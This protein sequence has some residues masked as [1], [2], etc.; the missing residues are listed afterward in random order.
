MNV[1][2]LLEKFELFDDQWSPKI[3]A[4]T[5][6]QYVKLAKIEGEFIW[7]NHADEDE[8]FYIVKGEL[9]LKFRDREVHLK[10]GDLYVVPK[11]EDHLPIAP[12]ECWV[13][14]VEPKGTKHTGEIEFERTVA[15]EEQHWI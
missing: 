12:K 14:L 5:N 2:N 9:T 11:G 7:H 4:E 1:A 10:E 8:L 3:I 13:L 15:E 6:G